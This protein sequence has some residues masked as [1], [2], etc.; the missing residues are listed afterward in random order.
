VVAVVHVDPGEERRGRVR[1]DDDLGPI[2]TDEAHQLRAQFHVVL[3]L[4]VGPLEL[5][6]GRGTEEV[7]R[8]LHFSAAHFAHRSRIGA[9]HVRTLVAVTHDHEV[10]RA[11]VLGPLGEESPAATSASSGCA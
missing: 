8:E 1:S 6:D 3:D 10:N 9:E 7:G 5:R 2:L 11:A 4:A